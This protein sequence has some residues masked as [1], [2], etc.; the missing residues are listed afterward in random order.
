MLPARIAVLHGTDPHARQL[1]QNVRSGLASLG[2][3]QRTLSELYVDQFTAETKAL[4]CVFVVGSSEKTPEQLSELRCPIVWLPYCQHDADWGRSF[5]KN[6][7]YLKAVLSPCLGLLSDLKIPCPRLPI[8]FGSTP[9]RGGRF[10]RAHSAPP[11]VAV[12]AHTN[13]PFYATQQA[14]DAVKK[15]G[16]YGVLFDGV[17]TL[18]F[19]ILVDIPADNPHARYLSDVAWDAMA[20]GIPVV[21]GATPSESVEVPTTFMCL[22]PSRL[23]DLLTVIKNSPSSMDE[24]GRRTM[25]VAS[26]RT[27]EYRLRPALHM[28]FP[29]VRARGR[30]EESE[31]DPD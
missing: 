2:I 30:D 6:D 4:N 11:T 9:T 23:T 26:S 3:Q 10:H 12:Y 27:W 29:E 18:A 8:K 1:A 15:A 25:S 16:F 7:T 13:L 14:V 22:S 17:R 28:V 21:H 20:S 5:E 24:H 19:D 31:E